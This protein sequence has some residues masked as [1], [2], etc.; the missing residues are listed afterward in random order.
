M[1]FTC[2]TVLR[3]SEFQRVYTVDGSKVV[4]GNVETRNAH[5]NVMNKVLVPNPPRNAAQYLQEVPEFQGTASLMRFV[6]RYK[7][8]SL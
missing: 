1:P 5:L 8:S 6:N 4:L 2:I 3:F 7:F